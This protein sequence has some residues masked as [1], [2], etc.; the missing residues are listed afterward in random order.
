[1]PP[2]VKKRVVQILH[3][4]LQRYGNPAAKSRRADDSVDEQALRFAKHF[5]ASQ[6]ASSLMS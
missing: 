3:R 6:R 1:M 5:Q 2:Q 4:L